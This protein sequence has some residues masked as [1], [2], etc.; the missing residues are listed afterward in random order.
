MKICLLL[1]AA[2]LA[3][4][5]PADESRRFP[6]EN[7]VQTKVMDEHVMGKPF[8]PGGT[9][10]HYKKGRTEFDLFVSK[11]KAPADAAIALLDWKKTMTDAKLVAS[12]GGYFGKDAS[13]PV[14]VF[15]KGSWIAGVVGLSEKE[16]DLHGRLLAGR[17]D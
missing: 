6:K 8:L 4:P 2:A 1:F 16:A 11:L 15:T 10:A 9:V 17:L 12:F 13:K 7:L 3:A 5:K 14:F